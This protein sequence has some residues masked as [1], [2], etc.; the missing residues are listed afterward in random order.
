[1]L[2]FMFA[3]LYSSY[4]YSRSVRFQMNS[5]IDCPQSHMDRIPG[6]F[7]IAYVSFHDALY[8]LYNSPKGKKSQ[9]LAIEGWRKGANRRR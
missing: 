4:G 5:D 1:M 8:T 2:A 7:I 6:Y 9:P 3:F